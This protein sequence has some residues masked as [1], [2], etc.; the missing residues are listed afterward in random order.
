VGSLS[1]HSALPEMVTDR[2]NRTMGTPLPAT[3]ELR[4]INDL[5]SE[6]FIIP[7]YQRGYR[8][9]ERQV[10][11]LLDDLHDFQCNRNEQPKEA[12]YC[13]QPVVVRPREDGRW[14]LID[15]QQRLTTLFLVMGNLAPVMEMLGKRRYS[16]DYETRPHSGEFLAELS[17]DRRDENIDFHYLY[18]AHRC[19]RNWFD[20]HDGSVML[21]LLNCLL[22]PTDRNV[23]IIWYRLPDSEDPVQVFIRL[24]VGKIPLTN[25]ELIR[26]LFLRDR[27]FG[28]ESAVPSRIQIAQEWDGIEKRLQDDGFWY[29]VHDGPSDYVARIQYLF[30]VKVLELGLE[31]PAHDNYRTFVAYQKHFLEG[32]SVEEAWRAIRQLALRLDEWFGDRTL[33]HLIGLWISVS[34]QHSSKVVVALLQRRSAST[35]TAFERYLKGLI[36]E[37]MV[38]KKLEQLDAEE[39]EDSLREHVTG[40]SYEG[41]SQRDAIRSLL[42]LFN[43][44]SLLRN[45]GSNIRFPFDL[46]KKERWD[47]EHIRSVSSEMPGRQDDRKAWLRQVLDYWSEPMSRDSVER[48]SLRNR[49]ATLLGEEP[50]HSDLF[51]GL[52][53]D[54]LAY[55]EETSSEADHG[56]ANLALLDAGTN[57]SYRNAVF[58]IKRARI[59]DLDKRGTFVPLCTTN[60]FLKYYST[61]IEQMMFWRD[62]DG[63][64]YQDAIVEMLLHFFLGERT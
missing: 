28:C 2:Y 19:I 8:W 44:A 45:R 26:A 4:A 59:I 11:E 17:E 21:N 49:A 24:N 57:R 23:K 31:Q 50:L 47:I 14:E 58:P 51:V 27:N 62:D 32:A 56:V 48:D 35:R 3:L 55:F 29:F 9:T 36:F 1:L 22:E 52:F 40:L 16:I 5:L 33:Y 25:A 54:I 30:E 10:T 39:T 18:T 41:G 7:A 37:D 63:H 61:D 12:F 20:R 13:L 34:R 53:N 64:R 6:R 42:L 46:F 43:I 15:G 60:V 38:G